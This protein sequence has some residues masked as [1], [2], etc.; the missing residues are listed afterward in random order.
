MIL[1]KLEVGMMLIE[2]MIVMVIFVVMMVSIMIIF[3][4]FQKGKDIIDRS[5]KWLKEYQFVFNII[6]RDV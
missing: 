3:D 4:S 5:L 2:L 6:L 1:N